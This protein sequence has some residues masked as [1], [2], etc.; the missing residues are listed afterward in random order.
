MHTTRTLGT[1]SS[2]LIAAVLAL[3]PGVFLPAPA[4]AGYDDV[5]SAGAIT[6]RVDR[7]TKLYGGGWA[8]CGG[9]GVEHLRLAVTLFR[10]GE[11]IRHVVCERFGAVR[12]TKSVTV[13]DRRPG[14]Q[15]WRTRAVAKWKPYGWW[16]TYED[17]AWSPRLRH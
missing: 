8:R 14:R 4:H 3:L 1:S 7:T 12:C 10:N 6:D 17:V 5:C 15:T 2:I 9:R 11:P 16:L 13:V